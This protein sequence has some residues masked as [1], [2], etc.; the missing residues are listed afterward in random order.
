MC[1]LEKISWGDIRKYEENNDDEDE[2]NRREYEM[3]YLIIK[4]DYDD[5]L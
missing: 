1:Y 4:N 5:N 3:N 2:I